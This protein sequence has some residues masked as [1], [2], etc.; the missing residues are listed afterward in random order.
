MR[1]SAL[2]YAERAR[3]SATFV[4]RFVHVPI[5]ALLISGCGIVWDRA[6]YSTPVA[7]GAVPVFGP[8]PYPVSGM[9]DGVE[10][11]SQDPAAVTLPVP[12]GR[13]VQIAACHTLR[14]RSRMSLLLPPLL[15]PLPTAGDG[16]PAEPLA[17]LVYLPE[18]ALAAIDGATSVVV[19][20]DGE[21]VPSEVIAEGDARLPE[22]PCER[23]RILYAKRN[24]GADGMIST[25]ANMLVSLTYPVTSAPEHEFAFRLRGRTADDT[26][27]D[28][29]IVRFGRGE[30]SGVF[31]NGP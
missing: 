10:A 13:T 8:S 14:Q 20:S 24:V 2:G 26:P 30:R 21:H 28:A 16:V 31:F 23:R 22:L 6:F 17:I 1:A 7:P 25:E 9:M 11:R 5:V 29:P 27:F 18:R 19:D 15:I 12:G 4:G 3:R